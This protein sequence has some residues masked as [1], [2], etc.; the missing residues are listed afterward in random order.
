MEE[1]RGPNR[2]SYIHGRS[3]HN[4]RIER[5]WVDV[6]IGFGKKWKDFFYELET[7]CGLNVEN[8]G[9]LWLLHHLFLPIINRD[10]Y[11][12]RA[13]WNEHVIARRGERHLSPRQMFVQG[14]VQLGARTLFEVEE[15][16]GGNAGRVDDADYMDYGVDWEDLDEAR[17]R[18]HH[19][20]N[21]LYDGDSE[22]PFLS[23]PPTHFS[24]VEVPRIPC[25]LEPEQLTWLNYQLS[26]HP[27]FA[28]H[29]IDDCKQLWIAALQIVSQ[30]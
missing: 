4:I 23:N 9:H 11:S 27:C 10:A 13:T 24:H 20:S 29:T 17:I 15:E 6:T 30:L 5:I 26:H 8:N 3:I 2:G 12:W 19:N 1:V 22:N 28:R 25:P 14:T 21:N 18:D 7:V 16:Q